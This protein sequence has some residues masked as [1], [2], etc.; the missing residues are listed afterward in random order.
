M[1][2]K[3]IDLEQTGNFAPIF[4]DYLK[5]KDDLKS[6]YDLS[7]EIEN[8]SGLIKSRQSFPKKQREILYQIFK[9]QY[10]GF[11]LSKTGRANIESL[12]EE[13]TF[14]VTTGHQLNIFTG[15]MYFIYKILT[16]INICRELSEKYPEYSFVP[17]YWMASE[18][19]DFE[20]INHFHLFGNTYTWQTDQK[21]AVGR[22][23]TGSMKKLIESLPEEVPLFEKA[24][25]EQPTLS[26]ATRQLVN[27]LF[28]EDGLLILD[29]DERALK[30]TFKEIIQDDIFNHRANDLVESASTKLAEM[31]YSTQVYP[32]SINFFYMEDQLRG[33]LIEENGE[34]KVDQSELTFSKQELEKLID[35][36][37]ERFS[38]NVVLRPVFQEFILPNLAYVGGPSEIAYWLQLKSVFDHYQVEYP[39]LM[40]RGF[41]MIVNRSSANKLSK[42]G[43]SAEDLFEDRQTLKEQY[44]KH[45]GQEE[46]K[47]DDAYTK[48][49]NAFEIIREKAEALDKSLVGF[50][51]AEENK[52]K[53]SLENIEKRLQKAE[54]KRHEIELKQLEGLKDKLF[55]NGNLQ[56]RYENILNFYINSPDVIDEL[57]KQ[58]AP[59]DFRF[60]IFI[61]E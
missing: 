1:R 39:I 60:N 14:T 56:E 25:L 9:R 15:P 36:H 5:G 61:D 33:R 41:A 11:E 23:T 19:H 55:P 45:N 37:P 58:F 29:P 3:K 17:V 50:V 28:A 47:L 30:N 7:P 32:R 12:Q 20:E 31:K 10:K 43:I 13:K 35:E 22:F 18:D 24:Y 21:G 34:Y 57:K 53:K 16:V 52:S 59:F 46:F 44:L 42:V 48:L 51:G 8:F 6:F 49:S 27:T 26:K 2:L 40:P 54:E 4:L 38:T